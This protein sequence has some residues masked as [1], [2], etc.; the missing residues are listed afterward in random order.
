MVQAREDFLN[1]QDY[2]IE[3]APIALEDGES[4]GKVFPLETAPCTNT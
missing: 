3:E 2:G 1:N 4:L